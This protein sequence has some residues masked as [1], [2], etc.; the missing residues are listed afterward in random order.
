MLYI[1]FGFDYELFLGDNYGSCED[2]LFKPAG[3]IADVFSKNHVS[4]TFFADVLSS[5]RLKQ[6]KETESYSK[7]FEKQVKKLISDGMDVQ[8]HIHSNW[9]KS[10]VVNGR[11]SISPENYKIHDYDFSRTGEARKILKY[12]VQYLKD[13]CQSENKDYKCVAYRAGGFMIQPEEKLFETLLENGVFIDSSVAP[14]TKNG[15]KKS[16]YYYDFTSCPKDTTG[17]YIDPKKGFEH[18]SKSKRGCIFEIPILTY[19]LDYFRLLFTKRGDIKLKPIQER[20]SYVNLNNQTKNGFFKC[21]FRLY[22][23]LFARRVV[24]LDTDK[25]QYVFEKVL[26]FYE[27]NK[28]DSR[29]AYISIIGH[30]KLICNEE[31]IKNIDDL[32]KLIIRCNQKIKVISFQDAARNV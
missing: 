26:S 13:L 3:E 23:K 1:C 12:S 11:F 27:K 7:M 25:A 30:P 22:N 32:L 9:L 24:S 29:D 4:A 8:L 21:F 6:F 10:K 31:R 28:C 16:G 5:F 17:W 19:N 20:G 2:I 14:F 15:L 18:K